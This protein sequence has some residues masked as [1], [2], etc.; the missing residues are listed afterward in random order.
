MEKE[1]VA[2]LVCSVARNADH[3]TNKFRRR[4]GMALSAAEPAADTAKKAATL[5]AVDGFA[6]VLLPA[7]LA[8][9]PRFHLR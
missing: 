6:V 2:T 4:Q 8:S 9:L 5:S 1:G 7:P 3:L